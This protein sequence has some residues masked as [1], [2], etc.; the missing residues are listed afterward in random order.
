[1][2]QKTMHIRQRI[3]TSKVIKLDSSNR[4]SELTYIIS[5]RYN[6]NN[7]FKKN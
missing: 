4:L 7:Y 3:A 1:M 5:K 6:I 2:G